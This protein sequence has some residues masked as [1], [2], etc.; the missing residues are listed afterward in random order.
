MDVL[1]TAVPGVL[2]IRPKVWGDSRGYFLETY[3]RQRYRDAGIPLDFVQD[4]S[5]FS[6]KGVLRGLH[7]QNPGAQ[8]KLV[9]VGQGEVLDV[10]VD[11]RRG[12]PH[13]GRYVA[14]KLS[15]AEGNQLYIPPGFAHGFAVLSETALFSYKC[16]DFYNP[17]S[18][19]TVRWDDP[20]IGIPWHEYGADFRLN[21][22]DGSAP[23]LK[24]IPVETLV[25]Y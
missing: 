11:V 5:S 4:N 24:D 14:V 8:G 20:D 13:F 12:S 6:Q 9:F 17:A 1:K 15:A 23:C 7:L 3:H 18:E 16:T 25:P 22:R 21:D 2:H 19:I 10:A